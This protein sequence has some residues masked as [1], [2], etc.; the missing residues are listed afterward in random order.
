MLAGV[1]PKLAL[2]SALFGSSL[3]LKSTRISYLGCGR[4]QNRLQ[5]ASQK[6]YKRA[7]CHTVKH[8]TFAENVLGT[9]VGAHA[10]EFGMSQSVLGSPLDELDLHH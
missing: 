9:L 6:T 7:T 3:I 1:F 10:E 8:L 2:Q 5:P 4:L